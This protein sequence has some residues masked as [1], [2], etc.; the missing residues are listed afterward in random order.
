MDRFI[1]S[2]MYSER[3]YRKLF[4]GKDLQFFEVCVG[5][6]DLMIGAD[7][8]LEKE[9]LSA[10][11]KFRS[12]LEAYISNHTEFKDSLVPLVP[13]PGAP[14]IVTEMCKAG[15]AVNVGPMAAVAGAISQLVGEELLKHA[16]EVIVENGGD[17]YIK[18]NSPRKVSIFAG[19]SPL[20]E[21]ISIE[22]LQ[23]NTP[24]GICTSSGTVGPSLSFG[25][26]DAAV[27]ISRNVFLAD[28]AAT[29]TGNLVKTKN[30]IS[31]AL[32]FALGIEG[33]EG[34]LIIIGENL[35][36]KGKVR[37]QT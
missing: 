26:A 15:F 10:V 32:D 22:V 29:A 20:S 34:A 18:T 13:S 33:V 27:I 6:S 36:V 19:Q 28:A 30:D 4:K 9:A 12:H 23:E 2:S 16:N 14:F 37:L 31:K 1:P 24:L 35:G 8:I 21:K 5:E 11:R 25:K 7:K 17:I 3:Q